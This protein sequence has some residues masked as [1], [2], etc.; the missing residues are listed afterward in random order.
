MQ[1][2]RILNGYHRGATL[3]LLDGSAR[4][5][6]ADEDADV[7]LA[8]PGIVGRHASLALAD[9]GWT[10]SALDGRIRRA[11]SNRPTEVVQLALGA[12]ARVDH[13]WI[14]VVEEN[15]P[16]SDPPPE[17]TDS[18]EAVSDEAPDEPAE[19]ADGAAAAAAGANGHP[20]HPD[21]AAEGERVEP[22]PQ[23]TAPQPLAQAM[24]AHG[25]EPAS[26]RSR[27]YKMVLLPFFIATAL[28]GAAAYGLTSH[29]KE[30]TAEARANE[31]EIKRLASL[32]RKLP[33][34]ELEA[35]LRKRLAEVDL[36][37][38]VMLEV[39][40]REWTIRG[41]L[42]EDDADRLQR[43][44]T[45]FSKTYVIDFP[46]NVKI[47]SPESML[48]FRII[49]VITGNDPSIVTDDGRR[50]YVGDEYRGMRLAAV[51]GN[52]LKFTGKH[53]LNVSW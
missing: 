18:E 40:R 42:S 2:L 28:T 13:I 30:L 3:P 31:A 10:L 44:L 26:R 16:W 15:V 50:L 39:D 11:E 12:L 41:A 27:G 25:S 36:L 4:L 45:T 32:P 8:D 9:G 22:A 1:E 48:P 6:G 52:Q 35:A 51:A 33:Q 24:P 17:P 49:Q 38:R 37:H 19:A 34:D 43:M 23:D 46:I 21:F 47:G 29:P 14:T 7:V 5:L 20:E 53:A